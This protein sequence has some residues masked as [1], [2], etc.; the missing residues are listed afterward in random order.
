M[1]GLLP[2]SRVH[3]LI[4]GRPLQ[5]SRSPI[6]AF[7]LHGGAHTLH[8]YTKQSKYIVGQS[9]T[10]FAYKTC[11]DFDFM[12]TNGHNTNVCTGFANIGVVEGVRLSMTSYACFERAIIASQPCPLPRDF[13]SSVQNHP[14]PALCQVAQC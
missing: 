9:D 7:D 14:G 1:C 3:A 8:S 6:Q 10:D 5:T 2:Q 4:I 12:P 13:R 11:T